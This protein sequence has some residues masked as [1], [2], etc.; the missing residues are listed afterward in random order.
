VD[1]VDDDPDQ[2]AGHDFAAHRECRGCQGLFEV[3]GYREPF[4]PSICVPVS[5]PF[6]G[7]IDDDVLFP[8]LGVRPL[9]RNDAFLRAQHRVRSVAWA[10]AFLV[11]ESA[12]S[13]ARSGAWSQEAQ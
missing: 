5:C 12:V 6:C 8:V 1:Q 13:G 11:S 3:R 2:P 4:A 9:R 7:A 10:I